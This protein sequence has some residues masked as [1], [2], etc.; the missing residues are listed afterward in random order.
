ML[1]SSRDGMGLAIETSFPAPRI[2]GFSKN[3]NLLRQYKKDTPNPL[4]GPQH[5]KH[6]RRIPPLEKTSALEIDSAFIVIV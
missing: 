2:Y 6:I 5:L 4:G 3:S 1:S